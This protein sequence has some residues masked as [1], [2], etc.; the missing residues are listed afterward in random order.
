[1]TLETQSDDELDL[2]AR[3]LCPDGVCIGVIGGD[4]KCK[5]C[6][7]EALGT[8]SQPSSAPAALADNTDQLTDHAGADRAG[9]GWEPAF[10]AN[11]A[12]R[13]TFD[14]T[15]RQ[16]CSDGACIGVIGVD[17]KCKVCGLAAE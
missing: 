17:G 13:E 11:A 10:A 7:T 8:L 12:D 5:V 14:P 1:M 3:Q 2:A 6:G 16:L 4:G 9:S 15:T